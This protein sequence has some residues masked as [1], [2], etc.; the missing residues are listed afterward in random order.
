MHIHSQV[1]RFRASIH[2]HLWL[3]HTITALAVMCFV[4]GAVILAVR[5][6]QGPLDVVY[7]LG[8]V[9]LLPLLFFCRHRAKK[10]LP[11][12]QALVAWLDRHNNAGGLL[13]ATDEVRG[14]QWDPNC[15]SIPQVR[16]ANK[17]PAQILGIGTVF[18]L[19]CLFIPISL[20]AP[21][22]EKTPDLG[23]RLAEMTE[24]VALLEETQLLPPENIEVLEQSIS[25]MADNPTDDLGSAWEALDH[26]EASLAREG[27][28]ASETLAELGQE[29]AQMESLAEA[30]GESDHEQRDAAI[31]ELSEL[32]KETLANNASRDSQT[33]SQ[34]LMDQLAQSEGLEK[35]AHLKDALKLTEEQAKALAEKL[36]N[37][38]SFKGD[39][40][41]AKLNEGSDKSLEDFLADLDEGKPGQCNAMMACLMPG[42]GVSRGGGPAP[43]TWGDPSNEAEARFKEMT[44]PP[45]ALNPEDAGSL[46]GMDAVA[47]EVND[48]QASS[49]GALQG[50]QAGKGTA[51]RQTLLPRHR[52]TVGRFF[53]RE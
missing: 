38:K 46:L 25:Q 43:L 11:Q 32:L 51:H 1:S 14:G 16:S 29:L 4:F 45:N 50:S 19:A 33:L 37:A 53:T 40:K 39:F 13:M 27:E 24:D 34:E 48:G 49:F 44:L 18:L 9:T 15:A 28:R 17:E 23:E 6:W 21:P 47:P 41:Q 8:V 52:A 36:K 22:A 26:L 10:Q 5:F 30:L 42:S 31:S 7:L 20:L 2:H 12:E 35:L 3:R